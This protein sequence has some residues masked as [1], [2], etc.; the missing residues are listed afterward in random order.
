MKKLYLLLFIIAVFVPGYSQNLVSNGGFEDGFAGWT[1]L[2]GDGG[3]AAFTVETTDVQEGSKAMKAEITTLGTNNWSIQSIHEGWAS[4][5]GKDYKLEFYAKADAAVQLRAIQQNT[6]YASHDFTLTTQWA[7]YEWTFTAEEAG[8]QLKFHFIATGTIYLDNVSITPLL[9]V[10]VDPHDQL[11][12]DPSVKYQT[13]EGFGAA[14]AFY[15]EWVTNHPNKEELYDHAFNDLGLDWIRIRNDFRYQEDFNPASIEIVK[16]ANDHSE[17]TVRVLMCSWSPPADLKSNDNLNNGTLKKDNDSF[18]YGQFAEYWKDA[19][20]AYAG[21]GI[22]PAWISIQNEPDFLTDDWET[23]KFLPTET[24]DFPGYDRALD[25]VHQH[26]KDLPDLPAILA[27]EVSGLD[28]FTSYADAVKTKP[29]LYGFAYHL[30]NG[31]NASQ[32]DSYNSKLSTIP[33]DYGNK[34]NVMTEFEQYTAGWLKTAWVIN[35]TLTQANATAYFYWDLMWDDGGNNNKGLIDIDNPWD[36]GTWENSKGYSLTPQFYAVKHFS[37]YIQPG[38][39]RVQAGNSNG[40]IRSS[41][42]VNPD[43]NELVLVMI[44]TSASDVTSTLGVEGYDITSSEVIQSVD[45]NMYEA[46]PAL[47]AR[48]T[49]RLPASS[50]T[51]LVLQLQE[52]TGIHGKKRGSLNDL[53]YPNPSQDAFHVKID[54]PARLNLLD[55]QG[56]ILEQYQTESDVLVGRSLPEGMYFLQI[57]REN[58]SGVVKIIKK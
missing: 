36:L 53:V 21:K 28:Y 2:A 27:P 42:F 31:G 15:E 32:P 4:E 23:C 17:D 26:I 10:V 14:Q 16:K 24:A 25:S 19:L 55:S 30:Y 22:K 47:T 49:V 41:A 48:D 8:L 57:V 52:A 43:G 46:A 34:P 35:N 6:G 18:V 56:R 37:K 45:N 13:M 44:N 39:R 50:V 11:S 58:G 54:S 33:S 12:V 1:N 29:Y 7:K 51:T 40:V 3:V 38:Y 9:P 20:E 5:T